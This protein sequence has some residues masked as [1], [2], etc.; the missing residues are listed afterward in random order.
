MYNTTTVNFSR[1]LSIALTYI[2]AGIV[3]L[4][5][6]SPGIGKTRLAKLIAEELSADLFSL[7][8]NNILPE[9]AVGL[10]FVD[11]ETKQTVRYAP[12]WVPAADGSDGPRVVFLD[13]ILQ[14]TDEQRKGIMS[15]LLER[16][17]GDNELP[18]NCYFVAAANSSDDG[19]FV[20]EMDSATADRFGVI[21]VIS[22]VEQWA[23][24][25]AAD[26]D[27]EL[28]I[29]GFLRM[30]PDL[31]DGY[32]HDETSVPDADHENETIRASART[33]TK[34]STFLKRA[35]ARRL[36]EEDTITGLSG[37][38]GTR[39]TNAFWQVHGSIS[40][41]PTLADIKK[42][43]RR[44]RQ[45]TSPTSMEIMWAYGQAMI[46]SAKSHNDIVSNFSVLDDWSPRDGVMFVETR[47][48]IVE[49]MLGHARKYH[50]IEAS[51]DSRI[52]AQIKQWRSIAA[53]ENETPVRET[54]QAAA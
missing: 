17:I 11:R 3:P 21:R 24:D 20:Y 16:Y 26:A 32:T 2:D 42:M 22:D 53:N 19:S 14:A 33:W 43:K 27:I 23:R 34:A 38:L 9:D 28:S 54:F 30:R 37:L 8:L 45:D 47:T 6:G 7:R 51:Q 25:F 48:H 40:G 12:K 15:A 4:F 49:S 18:D 29:M 39:I 50:D 41:L 31:F 13:E 46:W 35:A 10:Q 1:A 5:I 36:S 44:D 52:G